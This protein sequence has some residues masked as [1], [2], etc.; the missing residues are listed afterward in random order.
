MKKFRSK[1]ILA[2]LFLGLMLLPKAQMSEG[3]T[4]GKIL[5]P[6]PKTPR[7]IFSAGYGNT[8]PSSTTKDA[9][10]TN[11]S[12]ISG[13]F[14]VPFL[15]FRKGWDGT[16]K[17]GNYGFTIG[18]SYNFGGNGDPSATLPAAFLVAGQTSSSVIYRG[19][20]PKNPGFRIG[21]GP[22]VNFYLMNH[23]ILSPIVLA[24]YFST[25]QKTLSAVQTTQVNGQTKEYTL[26]NLPE[27]KNT[28]FSV[29]PKLRIS[30]FLAENF[31]IFADAGYVFGPKVNTQTTSL[32][33][34]G[35]P[36]QAG[37]YN[38]QQLDAGTQVKSEIRSTSYQAFAVNV[39]LSLAF[40][41]KKGWNG[42]QET[43]KSDYKG[44][45]GKTEIKDKGWNGKTVDMIVPKTTINETKVDNISIQGS[46]EFTKNGVPIVYGKTVK[47][48]IKMGK[49][50]SNSGIEIL[51][52]QKES[53][54]ISKAI[55]DDK[56]NFIIKV[57]IDT[58]HIVSVNKVE[59]GKIKIVSNPSNDDTN[60]KASI[61]NIKNGWNKITLVSPQNNKKLKS[62]EIKIGVS[63][64]WTPL[65]PKPKEPVI[66]RMRVCQITEEQ[67]AEQ[68]NHL[69]YVNGP[70]IF[71]LLIKAEKQLEK[72]KEQVS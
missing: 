39:G 27:T 34:Q 72:N 15:L 17:G 33:P 31:G 58:V 61:D 25:T 9:Y 11:S 32:K 16:V 48:T 14:F 65:V 10:F 35:N 36:N 57:A 64:R 52:E 28:G 26:L 51:I 18:G 21:G 47:G 49:G 62:E 66:N 8:M 22:Q 68:S 23:L 3:K 6:G 56:G 53:N 5:N 71:K 12:A 13:D 50:I 4:R 45:N 2:L 40:G 29:T 69:I 30:Y 59:Y 55:T 70:G 37:Q 44:W 41:G 42:K 60:S 24:E 38:Q 54:D 19:S 1:K 63:F 43:T 67:T 46:G 20:D 7:V